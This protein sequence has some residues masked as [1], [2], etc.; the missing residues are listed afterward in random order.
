LMKGSCINS[1]LP[2]LTI[3]THRLLQPATSMTEGKPFPDSWAMASAELSH[4]G[5]SLNR[6]YGESRILS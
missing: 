6:G 1:D 4:E 2:L 3:I 5:Y